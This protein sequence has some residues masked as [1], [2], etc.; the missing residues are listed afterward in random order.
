[1]GEDSGQE[2]EGKLREANKIVV[3]SK[4]ANMKFG[5]MKTGSIVTKRRTIARYQKDV[6]IL[7]TLRRHW[8]QRTTT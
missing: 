2:R 8:D 5:S 7:R 6:N 1:M 4:E 3:C